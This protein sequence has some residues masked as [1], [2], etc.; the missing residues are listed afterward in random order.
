MCVTMTTGLY[1]LSHVMSK[2]V[3]I[4]GEESR[5]D[6]CLGLAFLLEIGDSYTFRDCPPQGGLGTGNG[7]HSHH[8]H[9]RRPLPYS[10]QKGM[11]KCLLKAASQLLDRQVYSSAVPCQLG[12]GGTILCAVLCLSPALVKPSGMTTGP[13][14]Q[15][16]SHLPRHSSSP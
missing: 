8:D 5:S 9:I 13:E 3:R 7:S 4:H 15:L 10:G 12:I 11:G 6:A 14:T 16:S 2:G 1:L